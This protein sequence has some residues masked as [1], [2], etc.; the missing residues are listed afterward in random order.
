MP[1]YQSYRN[2]KRHGHI[3]NSVTAQG[4]L[5]MDDPCLHIY[6]GVLYDYE[7]PHV[8]NQNR[9]SCVFMEN[10]VHVPGH[11]AMHEC[12]IQISKTISWAF[13]RTALQTNRTR[14]LCVI[15]SDPPSVTYTRN[16]AFCKYKSDPH[17][18]LYLGVLCLMND[19]RPPSNLYP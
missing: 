19:P 11:S 8:Y 16:W 13:S 15:M 10:P 17:L 2:R 18:Y 6:P 14:A 5:C 1:H 4:V 7:R 9:V 3:T 12:P